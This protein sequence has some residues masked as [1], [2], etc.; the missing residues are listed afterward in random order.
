MGRAHVLVVV[1]GT[2]QDLCISVF[3]QKQTVGGFIDDSVDNQL[4][5]EVEILV[6]MLDII[7]KG[8]RLS[9]FVADTQNT[10]A[11][12]CE[13]SASEVDMLTSL[14]VVFPM[15][16]VSW[17]KNTQSASDVTVT[18]KEFCVVGAEDL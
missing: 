9:G 17:P 3:V 5:W 1:S 8:D 12:V 7:P 6:R 14:T 13:V 18:Q 16:T 10:I 11:A 2:E 4:F 15:K